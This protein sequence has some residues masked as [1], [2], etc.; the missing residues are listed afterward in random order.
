MELPNTPHVLE[1]SDPPEGFVRSSSDFSGHEEE[2]SGIL[3]LPYRQ[4]PSHRSR[5][6]HHSAQDSESELDRSPSL[7]NLDSLLPGLKEM[8]TAMKQIKKA[9]AKLQSQSDQLL[10]AQLDSRTAL[11][12]LESNLNAGVGQVAAGP[13][14][15][16]APRFTPA[17]ANPSFAGRMA[18]TRQA[19][20]GNM[21]SLGD[22]KVETKTLGLPQ[23]ASQTSS[24]GMMAAMRRTSVAIGMGGGPVLQRPAA[25]VQVQVPAAV[26]QMQMPQSTRR[27]SLAFNNNG[28]PALAPPPVQMTP[29][30]PSFQEEENSDDDSSPL[31]SPDSED[32]EN[33]VK[34]N[35]QEQAAVPSKPQHKV[36]LMIKEKDDEVISFTP[37]SNGGS[38]QGSRQQSWTLRGTQPTDSSEANRLSSM[39]SR[40]WQ[41]DD[42][43]GAA[44]TPR[45]RFLLMPDTMVSLCWNIIMLL[46][47]S[48]IA[49]LIPIQLAYLWGEE[50]PP[51][52][53]I[54]IVLLDICLIVDVPVSFVTTQLDRKTLQFMESAEVA[55]HYAVS[56]LVI[57][58]LAAWPLGWSAAPQSAA[59]FVHRAI[60]LVKIL[61]LRY[62]VPR[63]EDQIQNHKLSW[64]KMSGAM[65][66][67][68]HSLGC[69]WYCVRNSLIYP[70]QS[71]D[72]DDY[73]ADIYFVVMALTSVGFGDIVPIGSGARLYCI[74][75]MLAS[76][77]F[78]GVLVAFVAQSLRTV[79]DDEVEKYVWQASEFM[80]KRKVPSD[81][82]KRV[83]HGLRQK[84]QQELSLSVAP[85]ILSNL[86]PSSQRELALE[87]LR[88]AV[89][90]FPVF[91]EAPEGFVSQ[92]ASAFNW[93]QSLAG[94]LVVEEG[95][96]EEELVFV[97]EGTLLKLQSATEEELE[98]F[99][100]DSSEEDE[101][102]VEF[103]GIK[104]MEMGRG[105]WFGERCLFQDDSLRDFTVITDVDSELA[106][107]AAVDYMRILKL[108]PRLHRQHEQLVTAI[109][110]RKMDLA[111]LSYKAIQQ[112]Q[113]GVRGC[114]DR[115]LSLFRR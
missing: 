29:I 71:G 4:R 49:G 100:E 30:M 66:L 89:M 47:V 7:A 101:D 40:A 17:A 10:Q 44:S 113:D 39:R 107:L 3:S 45:S 84:F 58:L 34:A 26:P 82:Q 23:D 91:Q 22:P 81:L 62:F 41:E 12:R 109:E 52:W 85:K 63:L 106:V 46:C 104:K 77:L 72:A 28:Q 68:V 15:A 97:I 98:A 74:V 99:G 1:P 2:V 105:A 111:D 115:C 24:A 36:Q 19:S 51:D 108:Y 57:D 20:R 78:S 27:A 65:L 33:E 13:A 61:K 56:W 43:D 21:D 88:S 59:Y 64:L 73:V 53:G 42:G 25:Q 16:A 48:M 6:S 96:L 90:A 18:L 87:L 70:G 11:S 76:S 93:V 102:S 94:D 5:P 50:L 54:A 80:R 79:F 86:S 60:K 95:Q 31:G 67:L 69:A 35:S 38:E 55:V 32:E 37:S 114:L 103:D 75:V 8:P 14:V 83:E 112:D 9:L 92:L 110:K